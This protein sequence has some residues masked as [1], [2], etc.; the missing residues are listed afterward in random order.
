[1]IY[2][3]A[4][5]LKRGNMY[6]KA[7]KLVHS[8]FWLHCNGQE[9]HYRTTYQPDDE[10]VIVGNVDNETRRQ[11]RLYMARRSYRPKLTFEL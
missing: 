11:I 2:I 8:Q 1:L 6:I 9:H 10:V 5:S 4:E 3:Y 7:R